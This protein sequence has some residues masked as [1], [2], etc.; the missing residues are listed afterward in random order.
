VG[1]RRRILFEH[2]MV[3]KKAEDAKRMEILNELTRQ[4]QELGL[5]Y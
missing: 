4:A 1:A 2:L 3:Y 5:G